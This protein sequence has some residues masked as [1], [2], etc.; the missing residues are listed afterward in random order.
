[1]EISYTILGNKTYSFKIGTNVREYEKV[2]QS[3][4]TESSYNKVTVGVKYLG[5][6]DLI[7]TDFGLFKEEFGNYY[8]FTENKALTEIASGAN[9]L[10]IEYN[11]KDKVKRITSETGEVY[12][13]TYDDLGNITLITDSSKMQEKQEINLFILTH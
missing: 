10:D 12:E 1:M 9:N 4:I 2:I 13:Y 5:K 7:L 6:S 8:S 3:I 11:K